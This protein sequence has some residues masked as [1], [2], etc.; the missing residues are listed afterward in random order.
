MKIVYDTPKKEFEPFNIRIETLDEANVIAELIA[1]T[2]L[3]IISKMLDD[4][5]DITISHTDDKFN[6]C[7][8]EL[9][10]SGYSSAQNWALINND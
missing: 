8:E 5:N 3:K 6:E 7:Y 10:L 2:D 9:R 4:A 1:T